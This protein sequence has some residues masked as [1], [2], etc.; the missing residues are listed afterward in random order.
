MSHLSRSTILAAEAQALGQASKFIQ[1]ADAIVIAA[2][3]G[4]GVESGLPDFRGPNG[5]WRQY[6]GLARRRLKFQEIANPAA[7]KRTPELA[8]GFYGH[9]LLTYRAVKP[10]AGFAL[11]RHWAEATVHGCA[12]FTSNVDGQ[13]Q[14][15]GYGQQPIMECHGSLH[16]LQCATPCTDLIWPADDFLPG[17]DADTSRLTNSMPTCPR[18]GGLARP[19]VLMFNDWEWVEHRTLAQNRR[20]AEWLTLPRHGVVLEIGAGTA[21]ATVRA[22]SAAR[23]RDGWKLI[24]VNPESRTQ[25]HPEWVQL[26]MPA[27]EFFSNMSE[28]ALVSSNRTGFHPESV[29][30]GI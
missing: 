14:K 21:V 20:L 6:P 23:Q 19:N 5:L 29:G 9:R 2:G 27:G 15:A 11:M 13:F 26:S 17:V 10:H 12:V 30:E 22:F 16:F 1:G 28:M 18:C 7:F 25:V 24:R 8:W 4:L 3:A